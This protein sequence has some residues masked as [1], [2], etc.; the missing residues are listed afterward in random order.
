[1]FGQW[2]TISPDPFDLRSDF[3]LITTLDDHITVLVHGLD[4]R[5]DFEVKSR[6][7]YEVG[8]L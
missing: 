6:Y 4:G 5:I 3:S 7:L 2:F 1:M 8:S